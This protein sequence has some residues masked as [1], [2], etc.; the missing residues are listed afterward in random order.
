M[1]VPSLPASKKI[2]KKKPSEQVNSS[3]TFLE[4]EGLFEIASKIVIIL[5][6]RQ[7]RINCMGC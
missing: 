1:F 2:P 6:V 7:I 5:L 3:G 4:G